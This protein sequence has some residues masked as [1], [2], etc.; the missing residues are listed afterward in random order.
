MKPSIKSLE[1]IVSEIPSYVPDGMIL[2]GSFAII[3]RIYLDKNL[4]VELYR[5]TKDLDALLLPEQEDKFLQ[6]AI[7]MPFTGF[8]G[9][10]KVNLNDTVLE[11]FTYTSYSDLVGEEY[12]DFLKFLLEKDEEGNYSHLDELKIAD[13]T[14]YVPNIATLILMKVRAYNRRNVNETKKDRDDLAFLRGYLTTM[15]N[16]ALNYIKQRANDYPIFNEIIEKH[17]E[18]FKTQ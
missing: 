10:Y 4:D 11:L 18:M 14:F 12:E 15:Y 8:P 5:D 7:E 9:H 13:R 3:A 17:K 1:K 6:N 16:N 2:L